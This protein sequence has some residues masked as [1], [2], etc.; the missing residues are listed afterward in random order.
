MTLQSEIF[1]LADSFLRPLSHTAINLWQWVIGYLF[2]PNFCSY[3]ALSFSLRRL[4]VPSLLPF[5]LADLRPELSYSS[6]FS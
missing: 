6:Y 2:L 1:P 5:Y 3:A 4:R